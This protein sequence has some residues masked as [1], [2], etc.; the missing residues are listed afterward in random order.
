MADT[1]LIEQTDNGSAA[2]LWRDGRLE[3]LLMDGPDTDMPIPGAIYA[4]RVDRAIKGIGGSIVTLTDGHTGFLRDAKGL[5]PGQR[6]LV[7][8]NTFAEPGK[9]APVVRRL[10]FKS[11][12]AI[13]T[14]EAP[15][16]NIARSIRDEDEREALRAL[17][18]DVA[19]DATY[20]MILRSAC[21]GADPGDI[22]EDIA[23]MV[24]LAD[25][26]LA[27]TSDAP[28]LLLDGPGAELSAW[29]DWSTD[30]DV[31]AESGAFERLDIWTQIEALKGTRHDLPGGA[32]MSVEPT[33]GLVSIDV[34]TG[35]EIS[36]A[37]CL[38]V[39]RLAAADIPRALRLRGLGGQIVVDFAPM[40]K[41][42]RREIEKILR[43]SLRHDAIETSFAGWSNLGL[44]ELVRK[45]ERQPLNWGV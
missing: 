20:G 26:V 29:R 35:A 44:A 24:A 42:D 33:A 7:Q 36:P 10:L 30:A 37:A 19:G 13:V 39:N 45:R 18:H 25:Q 15:G 38:K 6:I 31:I 22:A 32:W 27:D 28:A 21:V 11:R 41:K 40:N 8:V 9:S 34:N 5:A 3:D 2:A 14:P 16:L 4:A 23:E 12:Y 43:N 17:A 1:I